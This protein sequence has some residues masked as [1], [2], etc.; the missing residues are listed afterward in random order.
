LNQTLQQRTELQDRL[1]QKVLH[2]NIQRHQAP[3]MTRNTGSMNMTCAR[4]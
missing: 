1:M 2:R 3:I 4:G